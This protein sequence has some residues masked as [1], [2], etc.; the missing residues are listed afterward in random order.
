MSHLLNFSRNRSTSVEQVS[1]DSFVSTCR[2]QDNLADAEVRIR[3]SLPDLE[4]VDV[5]C[6]VNR[7]DPPPPADVEER[8]RKVL[9]A[10]V[11]P[12]LLKIIRG[13]VGE[14]PGYS[15]LGYM[16]EEC[17]HGVILSLTKKQLAKAPLEPENSREFFHKLVKDNVR[18][19]NRCAAFAPGSSLLEGLETQD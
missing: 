7:F 14:G 16:I 4:V 13:L 3:V 2:L 15:D 10:R 19:L 12:G 11:G 18:L 17:C 8:L 5:S 9:G 6:Q 1:D